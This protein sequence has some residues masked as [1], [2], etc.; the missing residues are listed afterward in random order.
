MGTALCRVK[1]GRQAAQSPFASGSDF[2]PFLALACQEGQEPGWASGPRGGPHGGPRDVGA[3]ALFSEPVALR[4]LVMAL[5]PQWSLGPVPAGA[6]EKQLVRANFLTL[7][8]V[9]SLFLNS[10]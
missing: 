3:L 10:W 8:N 6:W 2:W 5:L 1:L 4:G 7:R 9:G